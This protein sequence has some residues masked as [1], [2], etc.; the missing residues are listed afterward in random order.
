MTYWIETAHIE[1]RVAERQPHLTIHVVNDMDR[2]LRVVRHLL[3]VQAEPDYLASA[4]VWRQ[5]AAPAA[6]Q[7]EQ[8]AAGRQHAGVE[9]AERGDRAVVDVHDL[10]RHQ[11]EALVRRFVLARVREGREQAVSGGRIHAASLQAQIE[12]RLA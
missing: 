12:L 5:V 9:R 6:H 11:I 10:A 1:L 7:I 4:E 2:Q 8:A 3:G